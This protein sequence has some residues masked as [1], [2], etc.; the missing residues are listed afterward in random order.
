MREN[1]VPEIPPLET[2]RIPHGTDLAVLMES[3]VR[4]GAMSHAET[5]RLLYGAFV[6][7]DS[8]NRKRILAG[9]IFCKLMQSVEDFGALCLFCLSDRQDDIA[10]YFTV[11]TKKIV[12]FYGACRQGLPDLD[13]DRIYGIPK[14]ND[15]IEAGHVSSSNRDKCEEGHAKFRRAAKD[16]FSMLG[17]LFSEEDGKG[18]KQAH[19]DI[20]NMY[21]NT[22]H[23][24][25]I[26]LPTSAQALEMSL[27][28][29]KVPILIRAGKHS[30]DTNNLIEVGTFALSG[31]ERMVQNA[32]TTCG[33]IQGLAQ[34]R[35][36][37]KTDPFY[38]FN[39][40][41]NEKETHAT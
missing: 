40:M 8:L 29:E 5:A 36:G 17:Q 10:E 11:S 21:F 23:G 32:E 30:T 26:F 34:I 38:L 25:R 37:L 13:I 28:D 41:R 20:V 14:V 19:S 27:S 35:L 9:E 1:I 7:A 16:H 4:G 2:T 12:G 24:V 3:L 18:G 15:L 6:S 33:H 22:K 31:V 39:M